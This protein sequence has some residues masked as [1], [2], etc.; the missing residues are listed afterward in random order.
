MCVVL[1]NV[2]FSSPTPI[3]ARETLPFSRCIPLGCAKLQISQCTIFRQALLWCIIGIE[4]LC[5]RER[6]VVPSP[7]RG[8]SK[9]PPNP[10]WSMGDFALPLNPHR[11]KSFQCP[12]GTLTKGCN[13][14]V[15]LAK[16][17]QNTRICQ[18]PILAVPPR[19]LGTLPPSRPAYIS[20]VLTRLYS[21]LN[22]PSPISS[23]GSY[24]NEL[25]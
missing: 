22:S 2:P 24:M 25:M 6:V 15:S 21:S 3:L 12:L 16:V 8:A 17:A 19:L 20:S 1:Q 13:P 18:W 11:P 14:A 9:L 7:F 23:M 5:T 10:P 4:P